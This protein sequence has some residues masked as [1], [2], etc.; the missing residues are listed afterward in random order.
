MDRTNIIQ[1][2]AI[3]TYNSQVF[4][5]EGDI[6]VTPQV[7]TFD[8]MA[9]AF[10]KVDE[11]L[12]QIT[13]EI[14]FTPAGQWVAGHLPVLWPY[15][16]PSLYSSIFGATDK[17]LTIQ[18]LAG[19]LHTYKAAAVVSMPE[20]FLGATKTPIGAITFRAIGEND[21]E[22]SDEAKRAVIAA[23]TFA[24]TSFDP[25]QIK[26]APYTAAWGSTSPWDDIE[27]ESG[28]TFSFDVSIEDRICDSQGMVDGIITSVGVM[29]KCVPVGVTE[30]NI[31]ALLKLQGSGVA[32]GASLA[33]NAANL[34]ITGP[35]A[36]YPLVTVY[37]CAPK[38]CGFVFGQS[39]LRHGE[40]G[41]VA[42]RK[43]TTGAATALFN[44]S[45]VS[46]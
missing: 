39:S 4:Y 3:V 12:D 16:N 30:A 37:N 14:G 17:D 31:L 20:I 22:W 35:S 28:W 32:R 5:T 19:S 24:D 1:G 33:G 38:E 44:V 15:Q 8:V 29:A 18:T 46:A 27:T 7:N 41:F 10:G 45:S 36:G 25:A 21:T 11:R 13:Y 2:P 40:L 34:V 43:F 26:T 9:S 42:I 6:T 23:T